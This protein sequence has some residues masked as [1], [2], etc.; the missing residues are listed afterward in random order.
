[1]PHQVF[2][3]KHPPETFQKGLPLDFR[4]LN[5]RLQQVNPTR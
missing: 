5:Q 4:F 1:M 2:D 3:K